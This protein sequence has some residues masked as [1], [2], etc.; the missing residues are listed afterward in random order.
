VDKGRLTNARKLASGNSH[1]AQLANLA[2]SSEV[3]EGQTDY[4]NLL[5]RSRSSTTH[6]TRGVLSSSYLQVS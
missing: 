2:S 1:H 3:K 5:V 6:E 4:S